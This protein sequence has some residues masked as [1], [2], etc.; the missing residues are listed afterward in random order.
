M[1]IL[2][3]LKVK[4]HFLLLGKASTGS[5]AKCSGKIAISRELI[6]PY[7]CNIENK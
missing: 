7:L 3:L 2:L 1:L 5:L 6:S 4:R